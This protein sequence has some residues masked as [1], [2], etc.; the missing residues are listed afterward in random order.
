MLNLERHKM[1]KKNLTHLEKIED[2]ISNS[3]KMSDEDKSL[4]MQKI[5]EWYNED[6]GM[7]LLQEQLV[8]ISEEITPILREIGLI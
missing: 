5:Q 7:E 1:S 2:A 3:D 4:A 8:K 6:K